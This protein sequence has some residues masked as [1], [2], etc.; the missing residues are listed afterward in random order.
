[1]R[2]G[3]ASYAFY[4]CH[5]G[6]QRLPGIPSN[7]HRDS[8]GVLTGSFCG[9]FLKILTSESFLELLGSSGCFCW[10]FLGL[11]LLPERSTRLELSRLPVKLP[12]DPEEG[13]EL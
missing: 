13:P 6:S 4:A 11:S 2:V 9:S 3:C 1:M 10:S 8:Q 12:W 5:S 7:S